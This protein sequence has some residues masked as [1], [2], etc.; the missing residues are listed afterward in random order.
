MVF[1]PFFL[2]RDIDRPADLLNGIVFW[3]VLHFLRR[4]P[5]ILVSVML[6]YPL[7]PRSR[8]VVFINFAF[9]MWLKSGL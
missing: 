5:L 2:P 6:R 3:V 7:E 9:P 4:K 1:S 8:P